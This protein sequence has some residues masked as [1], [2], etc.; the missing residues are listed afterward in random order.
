MLGATYLEVSYNYT[1]SHLWRNFG[2]V[3]AFTA[4]Y[5][6][7][8][9]V[10][11]EL[12]DFTSG[13]GGALEFKRS[14]AAK[15]KIGAAAAPTDSEKGAWTPPSGN[16][17]D[18]LDGAAEEKALDAISGSESVFTWENVEYTVPYMGKPRSLCFTAAFLSTPTM[19]VLALRSLHAPMEHG[20]GVT[21]SARRHSS[22]K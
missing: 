17:S 11:S 7:V 15:K 18:T 1:R 14:R 4:L 12:F 9:T 22:L 2:V 3:I 6:L 21:R 5:I 13:G 10:A 16:S 20:R 19:L 8:T